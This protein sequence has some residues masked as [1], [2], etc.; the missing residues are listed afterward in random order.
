M[1]IFEAKQKSKNL[2]HLNTTLRI[3]ITKSFKINFK[4]K[5]TKNPLKSHFKII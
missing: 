1:H 4:N 2:T 3:N 5:L